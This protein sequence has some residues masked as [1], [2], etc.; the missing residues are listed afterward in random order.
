MCP[1]LTQEVLGIFMVSP[2]K[3]AWDWE[4]WNPQGKIEL[5]LSEEGGEA[6]DSGTTKYWTQELILK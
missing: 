6:A 5:P 2:I 1:S 3:I 4:G